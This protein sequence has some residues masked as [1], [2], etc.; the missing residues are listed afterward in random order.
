M[1]GEIEISVEDLSSR[2]T[3]HLSKRSVS[4]KMR[5][6]KPLDKNRRGKNV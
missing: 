4:S 1:V 3:Q 5:S 6:K 2:I